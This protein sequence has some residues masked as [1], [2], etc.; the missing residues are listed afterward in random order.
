[1]VAKD[2]QYPGDLQDS[3]PRPRQNGQIV[4]CFRKFLDN[5]FNNAALASVLARLPFHQL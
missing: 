4:K 1:M 5:R 3:I 2:H